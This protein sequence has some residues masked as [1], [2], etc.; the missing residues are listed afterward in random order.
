MSTDNGDTCSRCL[1]RVS[2][3]NWEGINLAYLQAVQQAWPLNLSSTLLFTLMVS[4]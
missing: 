3:T 2:T 1:T 4:C